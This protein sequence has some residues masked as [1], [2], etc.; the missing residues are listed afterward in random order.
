MADRPPDDTVSVQEAFDLLVR[1]LRAQAER[2]DE[3]IHAV[4]MSLARISAFE[5]LLTI[6]FSILRQERTDM[7]DLLTQVR[8]RAG[9]TDMSAEAL[10]VFRRF[11]DECLTAER[12]AQARRQSFTV[13]DGG[14][15]ED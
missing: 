1:R 6:I 4:N 10:A 15:G 3:A 14:S 11:I 5:R 12:E 7:A 2:L 13:I 8:E 9:E